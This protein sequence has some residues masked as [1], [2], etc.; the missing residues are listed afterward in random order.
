M[1]EVFDGFSIE[2][3]AIKY[4]RGKVDAGQPRKQSFELLIKNF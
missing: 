1:R 2:Q 3:L 4:S